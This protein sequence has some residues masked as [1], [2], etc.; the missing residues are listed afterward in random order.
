MISRENR[1]EGSRVGF[2]IVDIATGKVGCL[3]QVDEEGGPRIGRYRVNL[4]DLEM[5][6]AKAILDAIENQDV[7][8]IDE[9]GP[10]ELFSPKFRETSQKAL[11]SQKLVLVVV[12]WNAQDKM[13]VETKRRSDAEVSVVS[14]ENREKIAIDIVDKAMDF[15]RGKHKN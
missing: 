12:H 5:I 3:A 1:R 4:T 14:F 13:V 9:I 10:M 6:G 2:E 11:D 7:V 15:L 8:A